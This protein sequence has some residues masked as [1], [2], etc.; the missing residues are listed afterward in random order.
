MGVASSAPLACNR[1]SRAHRVQTACLRVC[2][3]CAVRSA[4][5]RSAA[6]LA[7]AILTMARLEEA[8]LGEWVE[9]R[10]PL[11]LHTGTASAVS[12]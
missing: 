4:P 7:M 12:A 11:E 2:V 6:I 9:G 8:L 5:G 1:C 3:A 10:E